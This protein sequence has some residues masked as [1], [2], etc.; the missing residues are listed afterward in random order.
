MAI[1][2]D[3]VKLRNIS[4]AISGLKGQASAINDCLSQSAGKVADTE[5]K[6]I[7]QLSQICTATFPEM[8]ESSCRLLNA[9]AADFEK[10]D[11]QLGS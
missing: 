10:K 9:I 1:K 5:K 7:S 6:V 8:I 4:A 3:Y 2:V 11:K